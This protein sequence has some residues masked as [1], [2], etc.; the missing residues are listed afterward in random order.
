MRVI[1][2]LAK[3]RRLKVP[4]PTTTRPMTDM[5]K[6]A[7]FAMLTPLGLEGRH[8]LDL[9]A[10]SGSIGNEALSRGA[11]T[12]VFVEQNVAVCAIIDDNLSHT[13]LDDRAQVVRAR[14]SAYLARLAAA[15]P[16]QPFDLVVLDPPYAAPDILATLTAVTL[17]PA[18]ADD[19]LVVVGHAARAP[20]P[21]AAGPAVR[22]R[23][24]C[25]GDSCFSIYAMPA[26]VP[27]S[28]PEEEPA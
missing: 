10:G 13:R 8:V 16:E 1:T 12:A 17:S 18:V 9:Y 26:A 15:P 24:R 20:L 7:L 22:I 3:G 5:V 21:D 19:G 27:A 14:V 6:G 11:A 28:D 25:H 23:Y 2:G 4:K